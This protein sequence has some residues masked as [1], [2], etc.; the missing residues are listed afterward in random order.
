MITDEL[1]KQIESLTTE[2]IQ[3]AI[4]LCRLSRPQRDEKYNYLKA[5][6]QLRTS[7]NNS[8]ENTNTKQDWQNSSLGK[9]SAVSISACIVLVIGNYFGFSL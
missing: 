1:K 9:I 2:E 3:S 4:I 7:G 8:F 5:C 6:Y